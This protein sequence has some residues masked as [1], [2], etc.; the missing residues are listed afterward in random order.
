MP[1][2][3]NK[4]LPEGVRNSLPAKAQ[5]IYREAY[6]A[7]AKS[8]PDD[9]KRLAKI[10]WGAV[11]KSYHKVDDVWTSISMCIAESEAIYESFSGVVPSTFTIRAMKTGTVATL[12]TN[13]KYHSRVPYTKEILESYAN[14]W[15]GGKIRI[16]HEFP[17][18]G[19]ITD[20]RFEDPYLLMTLN[21]L[22]P[23]IGGRLST[24]DF[25][26]FSQDSQVGLDEGGNL[27]SVRGTG[28]SIMFAPVKPACKIEE[29]CKILGSSMDENYN[30]G[31]DKMG[32]GKT[33]TDSE[34]SELKAI[35][36]KVS[37]LETE[38]ESHK[39]TV[40]SLSAEI[41]ERNTTISKLIAT[42]ESMF[43][44]DAVDAQ[45][46]EKITEAQSSMFTSADVDTKIED[47]IATALSAEK[48]KI[49]SI[50][51]ELAT[52]N[53]MFP[54]GLADTFREDIVGMIKDGKSHDAFVKLGE[55][56]F[57][58]F[59]ANVPA[60]SSESAEPEVVEAES[61]VGVYD[62]VT[63]TFKKVV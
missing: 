8:D 15:N 56:D 37:R 54:D 5:S 25:G 29:G 41:D 60:A 10:A 1:Y 4:D 44:Q 20:A 13:G 7:A 62:P 61:G 47:A 22:D 59:K 2:P 14:T 58:A 36:A 51:S 6:N 43:T 18:D 50:A 30:K 28:V 48:D 12:Y 57:T 24:S 40:S 53:K 52:V 11:K 32:E 21:D 45:I 55:V 35:S 23:E 16:N 19:N 26:G 42:A 49:E 39:S 27:M 17:T 46:A 34:I 3:T 63:G 38:A 9:E 33:L 31:I